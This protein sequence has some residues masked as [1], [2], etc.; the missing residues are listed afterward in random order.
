MTP[1]GL[2]ELRRALAQIVAGRARLAARMSG[3]ERDMAD[4]TE[5]AESALRG[6]DEAAA[7]RLL[8]DRQ[9]QQRLM[10]GLRA[11]D[12]EIA[13]EESRLRALVA[14]AEQLLTERVRPR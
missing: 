14:E 8:S 7:R 4:L 5:K 6:D 11:R 12:S 13:P 10:A 2:D 9:R 3:I 1:A